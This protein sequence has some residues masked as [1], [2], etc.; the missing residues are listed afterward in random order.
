MMFFL[1]W[2]S[3]SGAIP[4]EKEV[5]IAD[6]LVINEICVNTSI[7]VKWIEIYN[8]TNKTY[9]DVWSL[10]IWGDLNGAVFPFTVEKILPHEFLVVTTDANKTRERW[11]IPPFVKVVETFLPG[12]NY[13]ELNWDNDTCARIY[14]DGVCEPERHPDE[15]GFISFE[16]AVD[17]SWARVIDGYDTDNFT[18]DFYDEAEPTPGY[19]NSH[20]KPPE[21]LSNDN[22]PGFW[23]WLDSPLTSYLILVIVVVS[24]C[25][26][27][28]HGRKGVR[29]RARDA[30]REKPV[31]RED[32]H[33]VNFQYG[34]KWFRR[35]YK[36]LGIAVTVFLVISVSCLF[37]WYN[38]I[39]GSEHLP[40][41]IM[42]YKAV[43]IPVIDGIETPGEWNDT[44][45]YVYTWTAQ[46]QKFVNGSLRVELAFKY[47]A[48]KLFVLVIY[49]KYDESLE[50]EGIVFCFDNL[51]DNRY[52]GQ[53]NLAYLYVYVRQ[54]SFWQPDSFNPMP[55]EQY[56]EEPVNYTIDAEHGHI[57]EIQFNLT[58]FVPKDGKVGFG[59]G[60][61]KATPADLLVG[62]HLP[63]Y[64]FWYDYSQ[65]PDFVFVDGTLEERN[66]EACSSECW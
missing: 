59:F 15:P 42:C 36:I 65:Y 8:P 24:I 46:E 21:K 28:L 23:D 20:I 16:N 55:P 52:S 64:E 45:H 13:I 27:V 2:L 56:T 11:N 60:L 57:V 38:S 1:P 33:K 58:R 22:T 34:R 9:Y 17:R 30:D 32:K 4:T 12:E 41:T 66:A 5:H 14:L 18:N 31:A 26:Y 43:T 49:S 37:W 29:G 25:V 53:D 7:G 44:A 63:D 51:N 39:H 48:T 50:D 61:W 62:A 19:S 35:R 3:C 10:E 47:N 54:K 40:R 6:H